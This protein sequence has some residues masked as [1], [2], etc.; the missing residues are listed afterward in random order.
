MEIN[1]LAVHTQGKF[2]P[3]CNVPKL[4]LSLELI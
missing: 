1:V 3:Y 4:N 2:P